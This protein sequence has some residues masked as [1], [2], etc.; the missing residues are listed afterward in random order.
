MPIQ[1]NRN[2]VAEKNE[3]FKM[4]IFDIFLISTQNIDCG[5]TFEPPLVGTRSNRLNEAVR[6]STHNL[7]LRA[8]IRK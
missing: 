3:N 6:M 7:C 4:K 1:D 8:D 2:F 5:Y